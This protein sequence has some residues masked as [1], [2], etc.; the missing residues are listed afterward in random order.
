MPGLLPNVDRDGL[1]EYSVVYTDRSINHMSQLFQGVMRDLSASLKSVYH[2]QA[3]A[4]VPGSG[5]FGMEAVARQFATNKKCLVIRNGW[6]SYRWTQ[7]FEMGGIPSESVVLKA[8][9]VEAGRQAA[10]APPPIDEVVAAIK[11]HKPDLVFAPHVETASGMLLPD[12]YLRAVAD[13]VHAVGG[14]FVLDCIASGTVWVDMAATGV[15]ILI[16][17]PQKGWS[18]SPC[19]ALVM[20][21]PLAR[22]RIDGTTSTSFA[23]DLRKWLQIMEAYEGGGFA[24]HA[25]MP[26][27]SLATLRNVMKETEAYGFAKVQAEQLELGARIR[28]LL[29]ENGFK[30]VAAEG[31]EAPGV[32]VC[33]TDDDGI[34]SGKKFADAGLQIAAG[35]PLQCDEPA[36]FKTFRIGLFGLDKLHDIEG[37]VARFANALKTLD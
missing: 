6:F 31:F 33:Y 15:D 28:A 22:E 3:V 14:M 32:V 17:A 30:S 2:A 25:T 23:C 24:Y 9:P 10:F 21:G 8:R 13:A 19:C 1:L 18:A 29:A 7:I 36:D 26:T 37:A 35:V 27:D 16:S 34:R 20:L 12:A 4:I 5:T 11:E